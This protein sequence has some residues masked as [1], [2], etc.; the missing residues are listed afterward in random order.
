[1]AKNLEELKSGA[2]GYDAAFFDALARIEDR[3]FWFR[4]R[5]LLLTRL[6][7]ELAA[8]LGPGF[9]VLEAGCGN[10][11]VLRFLTSTLRQGV[12]VGIDLFEEGLRLARRRSNALL[13]RGDVHASPFRCQ[14]DIIGAFD[15]IEHLRDDRQALRD[16]R[17]LLSDRG[18]LLLTVPGH[19]SLWSYFDDASGHC[20]RYSK[21]QLEQTLTDCGFRV[22]Y[23][24]DFMMI[25][26]PILW[27]GRR[28]STLLPRASM[29]ESMPDLRIIPVANEILLFLLRCELPLLRRRIQI[30]IGSSLLV[31]ARPS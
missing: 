18:V 27:L 19:T 8:P 29:P 25:L 22:E 21:E 10:G 13:V 2:G 24:T 11:N 12:V 3:H 26:F 9:R 30:P 5:N 14:F 28:L 1:M 20:R 6:V 31:I 7:A 23:I 4:F 15:V 17:S 16:L